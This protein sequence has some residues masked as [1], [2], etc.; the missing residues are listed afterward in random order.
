MELKSF[1]GRPVDDGVA[2][3]SL[4]DRVRTSMDPAAAG[5]L[6]SIRLFLCCVVDKWDSWW[7]ML[8]R[9]LVVEME[10]LD[11]LLDDDDDDSGEEEVRAVE[12]FLEV[13][14]KDTV[15]GQMDDKW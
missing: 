10:A 9:G 6:N 7:C 5:G 1:F 12:G 4:S 15:W 8:L 11:L 13:K 14:W 2:K 3:E